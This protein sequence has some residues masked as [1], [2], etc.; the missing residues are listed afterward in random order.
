MSVSNG[1]GI[2]VGIPYDEALVEFDEDIMH[3]LDRG[4]I[5]YDSNLEHNVIGLFIYRTCSYSTIEVSM[6][7]EQVDAA[8]AELN[9]LLGLNRT[10][11]TY[12]TL[13]IT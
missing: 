6:L 3:D 5:H 7:Q 8:T 9:T 11:N 12:L 1:A 2:L 10:Y 4:S 13:D